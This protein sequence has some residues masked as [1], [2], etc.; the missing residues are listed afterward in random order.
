M[1]ALILVAENGGPTILARIGGLRALTAPRP[2]VQSDAKGSALGR[3]KLNG[4]Q[5]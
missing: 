3:R 5:P 4:D 1:E 2:R